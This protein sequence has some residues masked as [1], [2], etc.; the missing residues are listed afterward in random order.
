[1]ARLVFIGLS[2]TSSWGNG[3]ATTYRSLLKALARRTFAKHTRAEQPIHLLKMARDRLLV[4]PLADTHLAHTR[5][6]S[7]TRLCVCVQCSCKYCRAV[8]RGERGVGT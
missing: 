6:R 8:V 2:I 3:H 1:M 7:A 4:P 5:H